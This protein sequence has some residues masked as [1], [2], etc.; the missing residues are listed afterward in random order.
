[1]ISFTNII[2]TIKW[3]FYLSIF[4]RKINNLPNELDTNLCLHF[5]PELLVCKILESAGILS[6]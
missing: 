2:K 3:Q 4:I 1:M 6:S 5:S